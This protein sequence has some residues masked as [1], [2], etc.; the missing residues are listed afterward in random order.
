MSP[1]LLL[2]LLGS[3]P[4]GPV[5]PAE[6]DRALA[7]VYFEVGEAALA[8]EDWEPAAT[9]FARAL[10]H[11]PSL[12]RAAAL[13]E[14]ACLSLGEH[15]FSRVEALMDAKRWR[16]A[17]EVLAGLTHAAPGSRAL[18]EGVCHLELGDD[19]AAAEALRAALKDPAH[20][21]DARVLLSLL[22]L[23]RGSARAAEAQLRALESGGH[24]LG[25]PL[26]ALLRQASRG[27]AFT[28]RASIFA[29]VD[30]NPA[31]APGMGRA[32]GLMGFTTLLQLTPL[33]A[34]G[35]YARVAAGGREYPGLAELRTFTGVGTLGLQLGRGG[36]RVAVDYSLDGVLF[37]PAPYAVTHGP[38]LEGS[39]QLGPV[40]VFA[41]WMLRFENFL[42]ADAAVFSGVR[43][44]AALGA[45]AALPRGFSVE[46]AWSLTR[47]DAR[48]QEL[49][50][51]EHGPRLTVAWAGGRTRAMAGAGLDWRS[52][53]AFDADLGVQREDVRVHPSVRVEVDLAEWVSLFV[54]GDA[55]FV[56]SNVEAVRSVRVAASGGAQLWVGMW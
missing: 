6:P 53:D 23:R 55:S 18:L 54:A 3:A 11:D 5:A 20:E 26:S 4:C 43:H 38:R 27:G 51:L 13:R 8:T 7:T 35:P 41:E 39:L 34:V 36:D 42:P 37:G 28:A 56:S 9:A 29:G 24:A 19:G 46:A 31:L 21:A 50:L 45:S 14:Q 32:H 30:S 47:D 1:V 2:A 17:L 48:A 33:G 16:A 52:Y 10:A 15:S 49:A 22:A 44:D 12:S 40:L 25:S